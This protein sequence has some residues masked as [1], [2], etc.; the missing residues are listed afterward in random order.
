M[1][2]NCYKIN[3][4]GGVYEQGAQYKDERKLQTVITYYEMLDEGIPVTQRAL[5]ER[6][7]VGKTYAAKIIYEIQRG[8]IRM[9]VLNKQN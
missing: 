9:G 3:K 5:A 6:S 8:S 1:E 2:P 7:M 4:N